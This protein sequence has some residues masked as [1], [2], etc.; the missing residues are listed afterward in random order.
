MED[1]DKSQ[2]A[3]CREISEQSFP[4]RLCHLSSAIKLRYFA[5]HPPLGPVTFSC[6]AG[7]RLE[8]FPP[9]VSPL[10]S[11]ILH[12]IFVLRDLHYKLPPISTLS[13]M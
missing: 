8:G 11:R 10:G 1:E 3:V 7:T 2:G 5:N 4:I 6:S 12:W 9:K 13:T